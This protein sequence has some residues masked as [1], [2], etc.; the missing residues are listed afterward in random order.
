M[1]SIRPIKQNSKMLYLQA[2]YQ[3]EKAMKKFE[4]GTIKSEPKLIQVVF[5][6]FQDFFISMG[7]P[8]MIP[9]Y[10]DGPPWSE[11][12]NEMMDEIRADLELLFQ[13]VDILGRSLYTDFNHNVMQHD[14]LQK[15]YDDIVDKIRDLEIYAGFSSDGI[16]RF[17]RDDF[18]NTSKIDFDRIVGKPLEITSGGVTLATRGEPRNVAKN[19][20]VTI[21]TG[22]KGYNDFIIGSDSNGFPGNNTEVTVIAD[23]LISS[24]QMY[25]FVG[26]ENNHG[27]YGAVIDGNPNTWFEYEKVNLREHEKVRI[28]KNLGWSYQVFDNKTIEYV[29]EPENGVLKLHM[30][31]VLEKEEIIN[32]I[33]IRMYTPPNYGAKPAIVKNILVSDGVEAPKSILDKSKKDTDYTFIF[34]P[35]KAKVISILFE[36][37]EKYYTDIGHIYFEKKMNVQDQ[38]EYVFDTITKQYKPKYAPRVE[39]PM[40]S[41]EELGVKVDTGKTDVNVYYPMK[42][43]EDSEG[44]SLQN[45]IN[46]LMN[47]IDLSNVDM[48]VERFEGWRYCIGIRDIEILSCEYETQGEIVTQ[49]YYFDKPLTKISLSVNE[50]LPELFLNNPVLKYDWIQYFISIDDG[51]TWHPITPLEHE[52]LY[53]E[54]PPKIYTIGKV[55]AENETHNMYGYIESEYPVYSLRLK[56]LFSRPEDGDYDTFAG[57]STEKVNAFAT[58]T[59][60]GYTFNVETHADELDSKESN[61]QVVDLSQIQKPADEDKLP[62]LDNDGIPDHLDP[63]IDNDGIPN[64]Q[65]PDADGDGIPDSNVRDTD[66][67]GIPDHLD[68]DDDNDG[69]PDDIDLDDDNDGIPDTDDP[70]HPDY[71]NE[72]EDKLKVTI[73]NSASSWC[74]DQDLI[75]RGNASGPNTINMIELYLNGQLFATE[76]GGNKNIDFTFSIPYSNFA[77]N[78]SLTIIAKAY[79]Y[80]DVAVATKMIQIIDCT[81]LPDDQKP[82]DDTGQTSDQLKVSIENKIT[83]LCKCHELVISGVIMSPNPIQEQKLLINGTVIDPNNLGEPPTD[84]PCE[85]DLSAPDSSNTNAISSN[86]IAFNWVI[87][88]WKLHELGI[89][90]GSLVEVKVVGFDGVVTGEDV[91]SFTVVDCQDNTPKPINNCYVVQTIIVEYYHEENNRLETIEIGADMLPFEFNNGEGT[92]VT[93]GWNNEFKGVTVMVTGGYN[94]SGASVQINAI[95]V[96]YM[97]LYGESKVKWAYAIYEES[98]GNRNTELM[99]GDPASKDPSGWLQDITNGNYS[100]APSLGG[101]N[102]YVSVVFDNDWVD[103]TCGLDQIFNPADHM[104]DPNPPVD[105]SKEKVR[106]CKLI[107]K[108]TFQYYNDAKKEMGVYQI[109]LDDSYKSLYTIETLNG[110]CEILVGWYNLFNGVLINMK[111][112]T[113]ENNLLLTA[114]GVVYEDEYGDLRTEWMESVKYK[115]FTVKNTNLMLGAP[116]Q[117]D[118]CTWIEEV[119]TGNYANAPVLGRQGA[120]LVGLVK[121]EVRNNVCQILIPVDNHPDMPPLDTEPPTI[122]LNPIQSPYCYQH[123]SSGNKLTVSGSV[124]DNNQIEKW[125]VYIDG[126]LVASGTQT[127]IQADVPITLPPKDPKLDIYPDKTVTITVKAKDIFQNESS[128]NI[129]V[130]LK[131]CTSYAYTQGN[132]T[133]EAEILYE[134]NSNINLGN[135]MSEWIQWNQ[136]PNQPGSWTTV[137]NAGRMELTNQ[138]NQ[139]THS[140]WYNKNHL[141]YSDY[142]I[143][144]TLQS[145]GSDDDMMGLFFR[146][147]ENASGQVV[148]FYSVEFDGLPGSHVNGPGF[149]ILKWS[150]NGS[151]TKTVLAAN[152]SWAWTMSQYKVYRIT[153]SVLENKISAKLEVDPNTGGSST[154]PSG[155][156]T[157]TEIGTLYAEDNTYTHGAWGPITASNPYT[158]FWDL[159]MSEVKS[160][161]VSDDANLQQVIWG[162]GLLKPSTSVSVVNVPLTNNINSYF[163]QHIN[164]TIANK[165]INPSSVIDVKYLIVSD[166][167]PEDVYFEPYAV[168]SKQTYDDN[169]IIYAKDVTVN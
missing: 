131:D 102:D 76:A 116:K 34:P 85:T 6:A 25:S 162:E 71:N 141:Q 67:D 87:P 114:L 137:N 19:A 75:I 151:W 50:T 38:K 44:Y 7:K 89:E 150:Y 109:S 59:L 83:E 163:Q 36:Q 23:P 146:V 153:V 4:D 117:I 124:S 134:I 65:D 35:T 128:Q 46:N 69:I 22:N 17:G 84:N 129:T 98:E 112:A 45:M 30:Q 14:I 41:L 70:D 110:T 66:G 149:R 27:N 159:S 40:I 73:S 28:A 169:A 132:I 68:P 54:Q 57:E 8:H 13:E 63:D 42:T 104:Q 99:L 154:A 140:G 58:P 167:V 161:T 96:R 166:T 122:T 125:E 32:Q 80:Q 111:T 55:S 90:V 160:I 1:N 39:G 92:W 123:L 52:L 113:G 165:G 91:F 147:N 103:H 144:V 3:F 15:E 157:F 31:I 5:Q 106:N 78:T 33:N 82:K 143:Q 94:Q 164:N 48:G 168:H 142:K 139:G 105:P 37:P 121:D 64:E 130:T 18:L 97:D 51:A 26:R 77:P 20:K 148:G 49:P 118:E 62:D 79:D 155:P 156:F 88:Y 135:F 100:T 2:K 24:G 16:L 126:T 101:I 21:V 12:Y 86:E 133:V 138:V 72:P 158:F 74:A 11:D 107:K 56:I 108:I 81:G 29:G 61:R 127:S 120:T 152:T 43:G 145:R 53:E 95:G 136:D 10:A 60:K 93:V 47:R 119:N 9:R 115:T